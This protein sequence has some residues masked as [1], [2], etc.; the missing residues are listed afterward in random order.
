MSLQSKAT[1]AKKL[2]LRKDP[3][4]HTGLNKKDAVPAKIIDLIELEEK[5]TTAG[6]SPAKPKRKQ[7]GQVESL[8]LSIRPKKLCLIKQTD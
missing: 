4:S 1:K 6:P 2:T 7:K 5:I 3:D 8:L